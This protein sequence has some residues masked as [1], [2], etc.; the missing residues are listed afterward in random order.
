MELIM[1]VTVGPNPRAERC[2][3][4]KIV[5]GEAYTT[6]E[7]W[8]ALF[9]LE[10]DTTNNNLVDAQTVAGDIM[11]LFHTW[12]GSDSLWTVTAVEEVDIP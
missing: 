4:M 1:R 6:G 12:G 9:H 2:H 11:D 3:G 5:E 7:G 8:E 10:G